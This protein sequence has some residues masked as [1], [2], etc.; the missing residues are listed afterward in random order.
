M[1]GQKP[2]IVANLK[3]PSLE[4]V[5]KAGLEQLVRWNRFLPSPGAE[6]LKAVNLDSI[7][8]VDRQRKVLE[9][10]LR[11]ISELGGITPEVS[12]KVGWEP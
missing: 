8:E 4:E 11:R 12:K 6:L 5:A 9:S 1:P 3:Y 7:K 10:I 2:K